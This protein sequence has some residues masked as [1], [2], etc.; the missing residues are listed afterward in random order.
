MG[1]LERRICAFRT[2][3]P[4]P[5]KRRDK[6]KAQEAWALMGKEEPLSLEA[7]L[8]S[9]RDPGCPALSPAPSFWLGQQPL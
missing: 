8:V 7:R 5:E 2:K 3:A 9:A 6:D 1:W 4:P